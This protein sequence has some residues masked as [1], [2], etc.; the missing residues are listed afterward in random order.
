MLRPLTETVGWLPTGATSA[1]AYPRPVP[2]L[3]HV[4]PAAVG[5][6]A[7][8]RVMTTAAASLRVT[9][10]PIVRHRS[11]ATELL[12]TDP[13]RDARGARAAGCFSWRREERTPSPS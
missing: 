2:G 11:R 12:D 9:P 3:A 5:S 8:S 4:A 7:I 6:A 10:G 13:A 1:D